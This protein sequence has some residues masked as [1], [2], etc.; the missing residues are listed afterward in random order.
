MTKEI[1]T[2]QIVIS[3]IATLIAIVHI[4][5]PALIMDAIT[6]TLLVLAIAPW[7]APLIKSIKLPGGTEIEFKELKEAKDKI[8]KAGLLAEETEEM[9][10][11]EFSFQ[12]VAEEDPNLALAGLRIEIEKRLRQLAKLSQIPIDRRSSI[13]RLLS[14][15]S[16]KSILSN[17]ERSVLADLSG[18]LNSAVHGA[19]V[20]ARAAQW[21]V[22]VGPRL[23]RGLEK[24]I[25]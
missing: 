24:K 6:L 17:E 11:G 14:Q 2:I 16:E 20:D 19:E 23:L 25:R 22:E 8:E 10:V 9:V 13:T 1:R 4:A 12:S 5:L 18:L 15:L 3:V 7:T 21:A